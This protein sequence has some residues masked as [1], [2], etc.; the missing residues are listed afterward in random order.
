[1]RTTAL[2]A[3]ACALARGAAPCPAGEDPKKKA[4][5][6]YT[7][8][9][10]RRFAGSRDESAAAP[11]AVAAPSGA[12]RPPERGE[13]YWRREAD[14]VREKVAALRAD[15]DALRARLAA[16]RAATGAAAWS[17]RSTGASAKTTAKRST[18]GGSRTGGPARAASGSRSNEVRMAEWESRLRSLE[19]RIR[20][21][22]AAL[23]ERARRAGALP[24]WLR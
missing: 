3:I 8:E 22:Q 19:E 2:V 16:A 4:V 10:L 13:S 5:P 9:D 12:D 7:N 23:E 17:A 11:P 24:G 1:V 18:R 21:I 6:L 20:S 14:R 15:A